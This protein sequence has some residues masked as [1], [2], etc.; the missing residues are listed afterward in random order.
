MEKRRGGEEGVSE[1]ERE[2]V[3]FRQSRLVRVR[4]RSDSSEVREILSSK[5]NLACALS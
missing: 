3:I 1:E 2:G 5:H 4:Y